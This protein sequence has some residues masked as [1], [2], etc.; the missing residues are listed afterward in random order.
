MAKPK[1]RTKKKG[2]PHLA[3]AFFCETIVEDKKDG[4]LSVIRIIDQI[5]LEVPAQ[6]VGE[7]LPINV[8]GL[9]AFKSGDSPGEHRIRL[10]LET[11]SGEKK[12][13]VEHA[14]VFSDPPQGGG[15]LRLH[16]LLMVKTGGLFW[17]HVFL[18]DQ[19]VTR[20]PLLVTIKQAETA[21]P[22]ANGN[23]TAGS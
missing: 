7:P 20:M 10:A 5:T 14:L 15:N 2:G 23:K 4:S 17:A 3:A 8:T 16:G 11:P 6:V 12:T 13:L 18:D 9:V 1:K 19:W 22:P 21:A